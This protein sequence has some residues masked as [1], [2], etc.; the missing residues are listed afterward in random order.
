MPRF[1]EDDN[2]YASDRY[3]ESRDQEREWEEWEE[4]MARKACRCT[5]VATRTTAYKRVCTSCSERYA[6]LAAKAAAEAAAAADH[7]QHMLAQN[8]W[9][10]HIQMTHRL[11]QEAD[12]TVV[13]ILYTMEQRVARF[14]ELFT[15]ICDNPAFM[16]AHAKLSTVVRA[17]AEELLSD[18]L[19]TPIRPLLE[20]TRAMIDGFL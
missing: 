20:R 16:A 18:P 1:S 11:L 12:W 8:P 5:S 6:A 7:R 13:G 4:E 3:Y 9:W 2:D 15:Y 19:A 10:A 14:G 17:K